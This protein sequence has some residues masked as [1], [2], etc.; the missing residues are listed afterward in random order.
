[1]TAAKKRGDGYVIGVHDDPAQT[2]A[3][4]W[5]T[6][7]AAQAQPTPFMRHEYLAAMH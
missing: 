4:A 6:L 3:D 2:D 1:L 5:N 7:L